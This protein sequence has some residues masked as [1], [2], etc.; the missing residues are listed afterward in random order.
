MGLRETAENDLAH[1]LE[2]KDAGF[3]WDIVVQNP[4]GETLPMVGFSDDISQIIDPDTGTAVSGRLASVVL[5]IS[6]LLLG[7]FTIPEAIADTAQKPWVISF[8][9]IN[10]VNY[11]F[12]VQSSDPDR[13][14]GIVVCILE[15][16]RKT[17]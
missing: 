10:G 4:A 7:G 5:R 11:D 13:A 15:T 1:I 3:G 9:D 6:S 2:D 8:D 17:A 12:K 14:L 16:Y